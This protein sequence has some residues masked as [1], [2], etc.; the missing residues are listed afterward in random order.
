MS[1]FPSRHPIYQSIIN[2]SK[3]NANRQYNCT[4]EKER[5]RWKELKI[6]RWRPGSPPASENHQSDGG[7]EQTGEYNEQLWESWNEATNSDGK[8]RDL[9]PTPTIRVSE[10]ELG[11]KIEIERNRGR[12]GGER[13]K[14]HRTI[15][16]FFIPVRHT[17]TAR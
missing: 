17:E 7:A 10:E 5:K 1:I 8:W 9:A 13:K 16:S 15:Q 11:G 12:G 14:V 6:H 3:L 4:K 2:Q